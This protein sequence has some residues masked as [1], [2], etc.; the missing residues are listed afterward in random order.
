MF[1]YGY[2]AV[3]VRKSSTIQKTAINLNNTKKSRGISVVNTRYILAIYLPCPTSYT[4]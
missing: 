1:F 2:L 4:G 3:S